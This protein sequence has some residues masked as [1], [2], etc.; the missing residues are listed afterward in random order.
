MDTYLFG[1]IV[2]TILLLC[3]NSVVLSKEE[4]QHLCSFPVVTR[5]DRCWNFLT[6]YYSCDVDYW[7]IGCCSGWT[8]KDCTQVCESGHHGYN[9]EEDCE[10]DSEEEDVCNSVDGSCGNKAQCMHCNTY[11]R[12]NGDTK[13]ECM[14]GWQGEHCN[15]P[16]DEGA[17]GQHCNQTCDCVNGMCS[18][19]DGECICET[20]W[21]GTTCNMTCTTGFYGNQCDQ[22]CNCSNS[23]SCDPVT[24]TCDCPPGFY[25]DKCQTVCPPGFFGKNCSTGC[26][27]SVGQDCDAVTGACEGDELKDANSS[28]Q[29][30]SKGVAIG[31]SVSAVFLCL[32][33]VC[34]MV[35][36]WKRRQG[37]T[38]KS[39][40]GEAAA[41][42]SE[43]PDIGLSAQSTD[44]TATPSPLPTY[45][46]LEQPGGNLYYE[47]DIG[48]RPQHTYENDNRVKAINGIEDDGE[49]DMLRGNQQPQVDRFNPK[50]STDLADDKTTSTQYDITTPFPHLESGTPGNYEELSEC[51][52]TVGDTSYAIPIPLQQQ[53]SPSTP[54]DYSKL[55]REMC[56]TADEDSGGDYGKLLKVEEFNESDEEY[57]TLGVVK[58][59]RTNNSSND[60][61]NVLKVEL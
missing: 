53:K 27:C 41:E 17:Y 59:K 58:H 38:S 19:I 60:T 43:S 48:N 54:N 30:S 22:P 25:G 52:E 20:G 28:V 46:T 24:G 16:C 21:S 13:C 39:V 4:E 35:V 36:L 61:Y 26:L 23:A 45:H 57:D 15:M 40:V 47:V 9:C 33:M 6:R 31:V 8:G 2:T 3:K 37:R 42:I 5:Y 18:N 51:Y 29:D 14:P 34:V 32:I 50:T 12:C 55:N 49:Y 44:N 56:P 11:Q 10:C 7:Y 1:L